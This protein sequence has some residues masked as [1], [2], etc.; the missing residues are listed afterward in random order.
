M[1]LANLDAITRR[2]LLENGMPIHWYPEY[3][4]HGSS[5]IRELSFDTLQI[6]NSVNLPINDYGAADLPMDFQ[7]DVGIYLPL[8]QMLSAIPK[9]DWINPIRVH[10]PT[11]GQ[12]TAQTIPTDQAENQAFFGF[13][14]IWGSW[15]WNISDYSEPVGRYYG[16]NSG[17]QQGYKIIKERR[18]IQ[19]TDNL[20]GEGNSVVMLYISNGQ[21][22]D[23]ATQ[24][25]W[26]A[27]AAIQAYVN[28]K[29]S[30]NA[31]NPMSPEGLNW[32]I[33][34]KLLRSRLNSTTRVD[35]I[36]IFRNAYT[37]AK[38]T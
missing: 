24:V 3:L 38:K 10:S 2:T 33:Q 20:I 31:N 11:T 23:N 21:S 5:A 14:G 7:D 30:S 32:G 15:Y 35:I 6:I 37:G 8:G 16:A 25:D 22:I 17:T 13:P 4:F 29:S 12:F 1:Q 27:F 34:R 19:F 36:N 9:Q 28:W 18:Q 26:Y